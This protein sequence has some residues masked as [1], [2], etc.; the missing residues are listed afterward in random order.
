[1]VFIGVLCVDSSDK[2][3]EMML[4]FVFIWY[5]KRICVGVTMVDFETSFVGNPD[6]IPEAR[7]TRVEVAGHDM[8][9]AERALLKVG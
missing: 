5:E 1:M 6:A 8:D 3:R 9:Q 7:C 2:I 4:L